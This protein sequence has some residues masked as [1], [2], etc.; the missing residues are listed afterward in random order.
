MK[1]RNDLNLTLQDTALAENMSPVGKK[2]TQMVGGLIINLQGYDPEESKKKLK[3]RILSQSPSQIFAQP[4]GRALIDKSPENCK[5]K[6]ISSRLKSNIF[7]SGSTLTNGNKRSS[8]FDSI[9]GQS[10]DIGSYNNL[11]T[12]LPGQNEEPRLHVL[13]NFKE[14]KRMLRTNYLKGKKVHR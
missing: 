2:Q 9:R 14:I 6:Q 11:Q 8:N 4:E 7:V 1:D 12:Y 13:Q 10:T 3:K 5:F